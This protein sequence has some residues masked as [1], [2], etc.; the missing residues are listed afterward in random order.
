MSLANL[1]TE[2]L[3]EIGDHATSQR[4]LHALCMVNRRFNAIYQPMLITH[5]IKYMRSSG[6]SLAV[7]YNRIKLAK[8]FIARGADITKRSMTRG[9]VQGNAR[10]SRF[11]K[12]TACETPMTIAVK[13]NHRE[14]AFLLWSNEAEVLPVDALFLP[15]SNSHYKSFPESSLA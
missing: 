9:G 4:D 12:E 10:R 7:F 8:T 6:L 13:R 14:M 3:V 11:V 2:L 15:P 5:N 1:P